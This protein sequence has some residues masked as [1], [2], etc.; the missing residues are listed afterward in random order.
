[1]ASIVRPSLLRQTCLAVPA[2]R[3]FSSKA[4]AVA[5]AFKPTSAAVRPS[6]LLSKPRAFQ[7]AF[8]R[9]ALPSSVRV[10]AFHASRKQEL[11]SPGPQVVEGTANDAV[12]VPPSDASHGNYHWTFERLLSA[13]LI[14][15]TIAPFAAGS[16]NPLTD[17]ILCGTIIIHTH[18]GFES[19][20]TDY[21]P[22]R[23]FPKAH[24]L[25]WWGLRLATVVVAVGFYEFE[26][27]DVGVTEA[28]KKVW[29]A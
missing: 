17:A 27:N 9:D 21:V 16:L 7:S 18:I 29:K 11:L 3:V 10:A 5:V 1:M 14:P 26:T 2:K 6:T 19:I 23:N 8:V 25:F 15:L 22:K 4:A 20:V 28:V 12:P 24:L 13:A